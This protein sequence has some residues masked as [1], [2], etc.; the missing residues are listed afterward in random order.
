MMVLFAP[1]VDLTSHI[2]DGASTRKYRPVPDVAPKL[3]LPT[4]CLPQAHLAPNSSNISTGAT[5]RGNACQAL[6]DGSISGNKDIG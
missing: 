5:S 4:E 2:A 6:A 1:E 3:A